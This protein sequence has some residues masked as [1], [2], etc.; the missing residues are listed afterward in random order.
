MPRVVVIVLVATLLPGCARPPRWSTP[1]RPRDMDVRTL[2]GSADPT[3]V[4]RATHPSEVPNVPRPAH[5][6]PC[7]AFGSNLRVR[8]GFMAV[9]GIEL[10][11]IIDPGALGHHYYDNGLLQTGRTIDY[12]G[13]SESEH[14]GLV[15]TCRGGFIDV[16]HVR[17]WV[18][19]ATF[20]ATTIA[21]TMETGTTIDMPPKGAAIAVHVRGTDPQSIR[22]GGRLRT[23]IPLA[24]WVAYQLSVWD[25]IATWFGWSHVAIFSEAASAFS[26]EDLYSNVIGIKI[27][28]AVLAQGAART[29]TL[30]NDSVDHWLGEVLEELGAVDRDL[31]REAAYAVDGLWWDSRRGVTDMAL[32][33]RRYMNVEMPLVPWLVPPERMSPALRAECGDASAP[34][35]IAI[36]DRDWGGTP[37]S[38]HASLAVDVGGELAGREP[39]RSLP[40][41]LGKDAF[42]GIVDFAR[43]DARTRFGDRANAPD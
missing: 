39:F 17:N 21:R 2:L 36:V 43:A 15:Y 22:Y 40:R 34:I 9:P 29:E 3:V 6:R 23:A 20:L 26:P 10:F 12:Q 35:P 25:E 27:M 31:A 24:Q 37:L 38:E 14:N 19:W 18:D 4:F 28:A 32:V 30:Y 33:R 42:P 16:A 11:N 7:C 1:D 8:I 41:R 13:R 5:W